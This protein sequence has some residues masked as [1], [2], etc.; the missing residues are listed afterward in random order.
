[1]AEPVKRKYDASRRRAT[2]QASRDRVCAVAETLFLRDGYVKTSIA[3]VAR[4]AGVSPAFIYLAFENKA[5]LL[6]AAILCALR[7]NAGDPLS[8][9]LEGDPADLIARVAVAHEQQMRR[10][11]PIVAL[12][13]A[14]T[15]MDAA[16][17]PMRERAHQS[18]RAAWNAIAERLHG[19]GLLRADLGVLDA[20]DILYTFTS[21]TAYLRFVE[22]RAA[23][24]YAPWLA[25]TLQAALQGPA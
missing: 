6:D 8:V 12:G 15:L 5:A 11:A 23:D 2:A 14:S 10:A 24:D 3:A 22:T 9:L 20:T 25:S 18:L 17:R 13:E 4:A 1:L 16:L 21:E 7:D 19:S